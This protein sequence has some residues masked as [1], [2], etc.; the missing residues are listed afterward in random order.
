MK[1]IITLFIMLFFSTEL[2]AAEIVFKE[3]AECDR[4]WVHISDIA[5]IKGSEE[6]KKLVKEMFFGR[7]P[8][9]GEPKVLTA[10]YITRRLKHFEFYGS[11]HIISVPENGIRVIKGSAKNRIYEIAHECEIVLSEYF[12]D[13]SRIEVELED[14]E[15]K[16]FNL[17]KGLISVGMPG[18]KFLPK[19]SSTQTLYL[20]IAVGEKTIKGYFKSCIK[21]FK[22]QVV[23]KKSIRA[24][25]PIKETQIV[26]KDCEV[27]DGESLGFT[28]QE[29]LIGAKLNHTVI[30]G[31]RITEEDMMP[32]ILIAKG[33]RI[34]L[35]FEGNGIKGSLT[36]VALK[37]GYKG[38]EITFKT[39]SGRFIQ[40]KVIGKNKAEFISRQREKKIININGNGKTVKKVI[41]VGDKK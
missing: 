32:Q 9:E 17:P 11:P 27:L 29:E 16:L 4:D 38:Q 30:Q 15:R 37:D 40:A 28:N 33:E 23:A 1:Y 13:F 25:L 14:P 26:L 3:K 41:N 20:E 36:A 39:A 8:K 19:H 18:K 10:D 5:L 35:K 31:R 21:I 2:V 34:N 22:K 12:K 7:G 6:E 24:R